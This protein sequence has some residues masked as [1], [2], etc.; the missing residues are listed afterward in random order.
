MI[1]HDTIPSRPRPLHPP[2]PVGEGLRGGDFRPPRRRWPG[3]LAAGT[4]GAGLAAMAV[5]GWYDARPIGARLDAGLATAR[6][7]AQTAASSTAVAAGVAAAGAAEAMADAAITAAVKTALAADP[8]LSALKIDV[9]TSQGVVRLDGPAPD[10]RARERAEMIA[11]APQ[12]VVRVD[13][14][15]VVP[16]EPTRL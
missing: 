8:A 7:A 9:S 15:L 5:S 2:V 3:L 14:R 11:A 13:N 12:G 4:L 16:G 10:P 1:E 6:D